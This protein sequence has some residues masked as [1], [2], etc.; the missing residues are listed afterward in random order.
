[1]QTL[2][3]QLTLDFGTRELTPA[4]QRFV[5]AAAELAA[6]FRDLPEDN[7]LDDLYALHRLGEDIRRMTYPLCPSRFNLDLSDIDPFINALDEATQDTR[8]RYISTDELYDRKHEPDQLAR[9]FA[10]R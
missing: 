1:M 10:P 9:F 4:E 8:T 5:A 3:G 6:A 2:P 7:G